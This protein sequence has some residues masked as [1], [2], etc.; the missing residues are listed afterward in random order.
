[1]KL[2]RN[3]YKYDCELTL[4][5]DDSLTLEGSTVKFRQVMFNLLSNAIYAVKEKQSDD[6]LCISI[7]SKLAADGDIEIVFLDNGIG[8]ESE[9]IDEIFKTLLLINLKV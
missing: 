7:T 6:K 4:D 9:R 5:L 1:M 2:A 8:I 3:D